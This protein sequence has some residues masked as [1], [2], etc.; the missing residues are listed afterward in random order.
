MVLCYSFWYILFFNNHSHSTI[1]HSFTLRHSPR[2]VFLFNNIHP[3]TDAFSMGWYLQAGIWTRRTGTRKRWAFRT[4][5][6]AWSS[7]SVRPS[8]TEYS[9][10]SPATRYMWLLIEECRWLQTGLRIRIRIRIHGIHRYVFGPPGSGSSYQRYGSGSGSFYQQ[11]KIVRKTFLPAV[12]VTSLWPFI[13]EKCCK[14]T[15]KM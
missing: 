4:R 12:F 3:N 1:I 6:D 13:F 10:S 14:C 2:P 5:W 11:A 9:S 7:A 15:L 8:H